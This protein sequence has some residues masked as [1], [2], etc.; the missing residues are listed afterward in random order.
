MDKKIS[1]KEKKK[2]LHIIKT[3]IHKYQIILLSYKICG[4][5]SL[6]CCFVCE[7]KTIEN[8]ET[9]KEILPYKCYISFCCNK[10]KRR[11][12]YCL[13]EFISSREIDLI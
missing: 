7:K 6:S 10:C 9:L 5:H 13:A 4:N 11:Y 2:Y 12:Y 1:E 8:Y 3:P